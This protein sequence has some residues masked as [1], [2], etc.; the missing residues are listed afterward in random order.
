[1][2]STVPHKDAWTRARDRYVDDLNKEERSLYETA[3]PESIF[4]DASAA[5]KFHTSRS[6]GVKIADKLGPLITAIEQYGKAL[7]VYANASPLVLSPLWGSIRIVLHL[8]GEFGKYFERIVD[9]FA[10]IGDLL[11][12]F[13]VY[14]NLFPSHE[15]LVQTL[16]VV[17]IDILTFCAEAKAVF[18]RE[19]RSSKIDLGILFKSSWKPFERRFGQQIDNFRAHV[20]N[21]EKEANLSHM[22]EASDSRA[23]V[24][25][26]Q[27][28]LEKAK[29]ED[30]HRR[31]IAAIPSVDNVAKHKKLQSLRQDGT[32]TWILR[33]DV[34]QKWFYASHSSMICCSGIP[35][36]G[37]TILASSIVDALQL[38]AVSQKSCIVYYYCDYADQ[39]ALRTETILGTILKQLFVNGHIPE[40]VERAFP[41][42]DGEDAHTLN[43][44][45]LIDLVCLAIKQPSLTFIILDG[46]DECEKN[47]RKEI[48]SFVGRLQKID[49]LTIKLFI[50]CRQEDQMLR[51][52]QG[53]PTIHL[54]SSSLEDDIRLFVAASV[55]S[56]ITSGELRTRDPSLVQEIA[57]ELVNKAHG[58][59]LW[60][61]FQLDNLCEAP[62][63][64]L[65]RQTLRNLPNGLIET[66][67]RVLS[68]IWRDTIKR[69]IVRRIFMWMICA[70][71]PLGIEELE[72]AAGF[73]PNQKSWDSEM[74]PDADLI[75]EACKGLV[76]WDR[77]D[78]IVRF[79]H[80]TVQQFL[81]SDP[82]GAQETNLKCSDRAAGLYYIIEHWVFHTK[83]F[84]PASSL[85]RKLQDLAMFKT[86]PFE[87]RP[88]GRNKHYGP[89]GCVSCKPGG[90]SSPEA[91]RLPFMSLLHYAAEIGHWSLMDPLIKDYC[92]HEA[93]ND[94]RQTFQWDAEA[95]Y[96]LLAR[97]LLKK[98]GTPKESNDWTI[99]IAIRNG[100][101]R[102][103]ER[104]IENKLFP[105]YFP[106]IN[107]AASSG[108]E[109]MFRAL[110]PNKH[111][112]IELY[113]H[114]TLALAA[115]NGHQYI[116]EILLQQGVPVDEQVDMCGET[117]ISAAA[118]N[119]HDHVV[120]F[121]MA[122][123][124][125]LLR[126]GVTPL[127]RAAQNGH[128]TVAR[129]LLQ[130]DDDCTESRR[131]GVSNPP[132]LLG[133]LNWAGETPLHQAARNGHADVV[134]V[135]L[136][137]A[138]RNDTRW[139]QASTPASSHKQTALHLAA[140]N[141]HLA[142]VRL[143]CG[144]GNL[145]DGNGEKPIVLAAEGNHVS[146]VE[147]LV[148]VEYQ[149]YNAG[150]SGHAI[151]RDH[152]DMVQILLDYYH[153]A[154]AQAVI[155]GHQE[156]VRILLDHYP[157]L[158][159]LDL[160]V[161]AA[162]YEHGVIL[163]LL[164]KTHR[165]E[166]MHLSYAHTT[167]KLLYKAFTHARA[168]K[169]QEA[170]Q[171]LEHYWRQEET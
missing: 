114:I 52:L 28:Q 20:K 110:L 6:S 71:R 118:A 132:D 127:H 128:A 35:G 160:L 82:N 91:E 156:V 15:R 32:G 58:M 119:G 106:M 67:E 164:I 165:E 26:N 147:A 9:M 155:K 72:E 54:T 99:C 97:P 16:S 111:A 83:E 95:K 18:R 41:R 55:S 53:V 17:Y 31:I 77:E 10:R 168:D 59:F 46:L 80:L 129:T 140:A 62:S 39:R 73:E 169:L 93:E 48:L 92:S 171:L 143:L 159:R 157:I 47:T 61:F 94:S 112:Y 69:D 145:A 1:M 102:I 14:E 66:Y 60:V 153:T 135:M 70:Q 105:V 50:S 136:E 21:V 19:R 166:S 100:H 96:W 68:K 144:Y 133:A 115:A 36:C 4:C 123:G 42:G 151:S 152:Y 29:R 81:L 148:E 122:N 45:N 49:T 7:D 57:D 2:G 76:I 125:R 150:N 40:A 33:H 24:L 13:R 142:V 117:P 85:S 109:I 126:E 158:V 63:D 78:G 43:V 74:L 137:H 30:A 116:V 64:A 89:Y 130:A 75:I 87:F 163:E 121:L 113:G 146:V 5:E 3:S 167:K 104:L 162:R 22:I 37:K 120:Q 84:D 134:R 139:L 56:R 90:T 124:A 149:G 107:A 88:W 161:L 86:L 44:N 8:A 65:I 27:R 103:F 34:Y 79:A 101:E 131:L 12:R 25:A 98:H 170:A 11:P 51:S 138:P 38:E 154:L 23:V 141:G 108:H